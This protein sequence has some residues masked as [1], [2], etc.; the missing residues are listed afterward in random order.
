MRS[1]TSTCTQG[2]ALHSQ[3]EH[4]VEYQYVSLFPLFLYAR[5]RSQA[6]LAV[7]RHVTVVVRV[8]CFTFPSFGVFS[9]STSY[10]GLYLCSGRH[11]HARSPS[12]AIPVS[13]RPMTFLD[14]SYDLC[15][16]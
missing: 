3:G 14:S 9:A 1:R 2:R 6:V 12:L 8:R 7:R 15:I 11:T 16:A 13:P 10:C 5:S 4:R